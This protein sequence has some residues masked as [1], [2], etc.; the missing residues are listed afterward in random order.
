MNYLE[1][2]NKVLDESGKEQ[3]PLTLLNWSSAEAGRRLYP[4]VKRLVAEAW[5]MIQMKRNEWEFNSGEFVMT[6]NPRIRFTDGAATVAPSLGT[7]WRG[8]E[9]GVAITVTAID[10]IA[11]AWA[12]GDAYGQV[13]FTTDATNP[14][15]LGETFEDDGGDGVFEYSDPGSY[16]LLWG[17][18]QVREPRWNTFRARRAGD[19]YNNMVFVP[20]SN[21]IVGGLT[22]AHSNTTPYYFSQDYM[23]NLVFYGQTMQ[24]FQLTFIYDVAPQTL[25][26]PEDTPE[27]LPA[28]YH[29]WI[30]WQALVNLARFDKD[31]DLYA[32]ANEQVIVYRQ[33][34]ERNLMPIVEWAASN[35]DYC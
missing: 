1:L 12:D 31:P 35:Y 24:P 11:G 10:L 26:D 13:E 5:K 19:M 28:E 25:S 9:S 3:N 16:S 22:Y 7:V 29:E 17:P 14:P 8:A 30:A 15:I 20:W 23:G 27:G 21:F 4:R 18:G 32:Y 34:A 2:C 6:I 33:R